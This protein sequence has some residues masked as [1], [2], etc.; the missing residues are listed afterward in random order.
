MRISF[1]FDGTLLRTAIDPEE[2]VVALGANHKWL[3]VV[4]KAVR[5]GHEVIIVTSRFRRFE[6]DEGRVCIRSFIATH[7]LPISG[8]FW[9]EGAWKAPL[10]QSMGVAIH[11]DDDPD[12]VAR[13]AGLSVRGV[14]V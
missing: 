7:R 2:G 6:G 1:D 11:F 10:L 9:T 13:C 5:K 14:L 8:V 4:R 3:R 12:E